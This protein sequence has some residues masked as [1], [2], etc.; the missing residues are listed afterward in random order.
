ML[1]AAITRPTLNEKKQPEAANA[2]PGDRVVPNPRRRLLALSALGA[3][4]PWDS[5]YAQAMP[6]RPVIALVTKSLD[7]QFGRAMWDSAKDYQQHNSNE[8]DLVA[9]GIAD[10]ADT[11][12]QIGIMHDMI[13]TKVNAIV[14]AAVDSK[15]LVPVVASAIGA[16]IIV[17]T[18]DNR[19]DDD[20][21]K[22]Y[23]IH[24]PFVGPDDHKGAMLV[25]NYVAAR[26]VH[27]DEVGIIAGPENESNAQQRT[28]GFIDA[29]RAHGVRVIAVR[30]GQ[31]QTAAA[32][33]VA[34][35][36]LRQ[37]PQIRALLC[38][39]DP[40]AIGAA[41]A[42]EAA[43][44][45]GRVYVSG[46]DNIAPVRQMLRDGA[47]LATADH[48]PAKQGVFGIDFALKAV[49]GRKKQDELSAFFET[50]VQLVTAAP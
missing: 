32:S 28:A 21:L 3:I 7:K 19:L 34:A 36:M 22:N 9:A 18:I 42:V 30:S 23:S 11:T 37:H 39:N 47:V 26:L 16:G 48:F 14:L 45:K 43:G 17:I 24:V 2:H 4:W 40:M 35:D 29:M 38:G 41:K 50:P 1:F 12:A 44:L 46:Y 15:A 25:G 33:A 8:F 6:S 10:D 20:A 27:A 31:W 13:R 49:A 5:G